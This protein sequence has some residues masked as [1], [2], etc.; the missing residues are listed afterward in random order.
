[1]HQKILIIDDEPT[2]IRILKDR[3]T[4]NGYEV[5]TA[6]DGQEGLDMARSQGPDLILLDLML[7]KMNGF[8]VCRILKFD[9]VYSKIPIILVTARAS[10]SDMKTGKEVGADAYIVKPIDFNV[11]METIKIHLKIEIKL[12]TEAG[13]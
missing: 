7:P 3:L 6:S 5:S 11:L 13:R 10:E 1:M 8:E 9:E 12:Q 2:L 4:K